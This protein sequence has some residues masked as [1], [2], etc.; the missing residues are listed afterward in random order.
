VTLAD[1][2][3]IPDI[4]RGYESMFS[5]F[6]DADCIALKA[7]IARTELQ[8][9]MK[10]RLSLREDSA[11]DDYID[12]NQTLTRRAM[13]LKAMTLWFVDN[14]QGDGTMNRSKRDYYNRLYGQ[15]LSSMMLPSGPSATTIILR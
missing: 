11:L 15:A 10:L 2:T 13:T 14:D 12:A 8:Y 4:M 1:V 5:D 6:T 9:D 3:S 7:D